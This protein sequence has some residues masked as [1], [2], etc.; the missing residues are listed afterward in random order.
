M[1]ADFRALCLQDLSETWHEDQAARV[2]TVHNRV[3]TWKRLF[4]YFARPRGLQTKVRIGALNYAGGYECELVPKQPPD[5]W[6]RFIDVGAQVGV[7][8]TELMSLHRKYEGAPAKT[9]RA[10]AQRKLGNRVG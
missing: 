1:F 7:P 8:M 9:I 2:R 5:L 6:E 4:T 10:S 3:Q